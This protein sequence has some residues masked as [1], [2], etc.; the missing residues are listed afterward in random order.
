MD[1]ISEV[2]YQIFRPYL[3]HMV[4]SPTLLLL[5]ILYYYL[6]KYAILVSVRSCNRKQS[7]RTTSFCPVIRWLCWMS[8]FRFLCPVVVVSSSS[9]S[10][11][12]LQW[13]S[14][15]MAFFIIFRLML[16]RN[17]IPRDFYRTLA[18]YLVRLVLSSSTDIPCL[19]L[20]G[21]TLCHGPSFHWQ[22]SSSVGRYWV[23]TLTASNHPT[24]RTFIFNRWTKVFL[25]QCQLYGTRLSDLGIE[26]LRFYSVRESGS[27]DSALSTVF[28]SLCVC[29]C[30]MHSYASRTEST[31]TQ[32]DPIRTELLIVKISLPLCA[33]WPK[34]QYCVSMLTY[35]FMVSIQT[36]W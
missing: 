11:N 9:S 29:V 7:C 4:R 33:V 3:P 14:Y 6:V 20:I 35:G 26:I 17:P 22:S 27:R 12:V 19:M 13:P 1:C 5:S 24:H 36:G 23:S 18:T 16:Y 2:L 21:L 34:C 31:Q 28:S 15:R 25:V 10:A 8:P 32:W 30:V